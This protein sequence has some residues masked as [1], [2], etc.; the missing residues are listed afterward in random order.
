MANFGGD[1]KTTAPVSEDNLDTCY[2]L[3]T[4][5][6]TGVQHTNLATAFGGKAM[7]SNTGELYVCGGTGITFQMTKKGWEA[8]SP[9]HHPSPHSAPTGVGADPP[10]YICNIC[11]ACC[12]QQSN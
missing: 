9:P 8:L 1:P 12:E 6:E 10:E 7:M 2:K 11:P 3:P 4:Y 5:V